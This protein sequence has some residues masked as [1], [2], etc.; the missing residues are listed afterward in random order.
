LGFG[1]NFPVLVMGKQRATGGAA[2]EDV[3]YVRNPPIFIFI[4]ILPCGTFG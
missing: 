3:C 4:Q 2:K 1:E